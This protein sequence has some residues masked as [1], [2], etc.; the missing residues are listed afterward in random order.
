VTGLDAE[1]ADVVDRPPADDAV[2]DGPFELALEI[3]L[4]R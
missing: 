3:G 4:H 2:E 1:T